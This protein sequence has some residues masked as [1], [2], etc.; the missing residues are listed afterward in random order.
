M[1]I[2]VNSACQEITSSEAVTVYTPKNFKIS[3]PLPILQVTKTIKAASHQ[4]DKDTNNRIC[5][6]LHVTLIAAAL[7]CLRKPSGQN[8]DGIRTNIKVFVTNTNQNNDENNI[9]TI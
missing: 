5:E 1:A 6:I 4:N 9:A 7:H 3:E 2:E 8:K